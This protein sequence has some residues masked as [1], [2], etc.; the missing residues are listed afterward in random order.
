MGNCFK[1]LFQ[2]KESKL[3]IEDKTKYSWD[4]KQPLVI[5]F[6]RHG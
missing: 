3:S 6:S 4:I 1:K 2:T 5:Y